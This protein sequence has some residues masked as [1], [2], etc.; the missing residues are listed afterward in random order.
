MLNN[1]W[2][3]LHEF[4]LTTGEYVKSRPAG[5][6][7]NGEPVLVSA[8]AT[9]D[10]P[11][12]EKEGHKQ[13]WVAMGAQSQYAETDLVLSSKGQTGAWYYI[14]DHR[15]V[16]GKDGVKSGG[17]KY[18]LPDDGYLA[19]PRY[20][21]KLGALPSDAR[22]TEPEKPL[23]VVRTEKRAEIQRG[24]EAALV[25]TLTMPSSSPGQGEIATQAALF[26][27]TDAEGLDY[28]LSSLAAERDAL[29]ESVADATS[30]EEVGAVAVNYPV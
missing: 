22:L 30:R 20:M 10:A 25:A 16:M 14:V 17:T 5:K 23:E 19:P 6:R 3:Q 9:P 27:A 8:A 11:G 2:P 18:W 15:Q 29:M 28:V 4:D 7:P 12:P 13:V 24:Y 21:E 1:T 26:A